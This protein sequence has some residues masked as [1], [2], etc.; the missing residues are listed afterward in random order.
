MRTVQLERRGVLIRSVLLFATPLVPSLPAVADSGV[1]V[2]G[3]ESAGSSANFNR[4]QTGKPRPET[5]CVLLEEVQSSSGNGKV[6][7]ISAELVTNGG[8]AASVAFESPWPVARGMYYDVEARSQEGDSAY[9][10]VRTLPSD[11]DVMA[12]KASYLTSSVFN[13]YGRWSTY[14]APTDVKVL[15]DE[16]VGTVRYLD[17]SFSVLSQSG[18]ESIRRGVIAAIQPKGSNDAI[19]LVSSATSVRW[20]KGAEAGA[21]QAAQ[22][23][24]MT[25]T[26]PTKNPRAFSS[27]YR[28]EERGGLTKSAGDTTQELINAL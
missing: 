2:S 10:H 21:R 13:P 6:S 26:R 9:L 27:D 15:S 23:F 11:K 5:G 7:T 18:P 25:R 1:S 14:G 4:L 20:K 8:V 12:V 19:M 28:F 3:G 17:V 24:R 16:T 22:S